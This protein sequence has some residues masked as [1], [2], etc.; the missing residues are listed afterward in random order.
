MK[1][2]LTSLILTAGVA[3]LALVFAPSSHAQTNLLTGNPLTNAPA[4]LTIGQETTF[5]S[6]V[7]SYFS[8]FDT[9][10]LTFKKTNEFDITAGADTQAG[11]TSAS[12]GINYSL[13]NNVGLDEVTRGAGI[14]G[15]IVSQQAGVSLSKVYYDVKLTAYLDGGWDF[16]QKSAFAEFGV[17]AF[18]ALTENTFAGVGLALQADKSGLR[19]SPLI[20]IFTGF[21]F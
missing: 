16:N 15:V 3:I 13:W 1:N 20:S 19:E 11:I 10:S 14:G 12:L 21:T 5:I 4:G 18:K 7:Q 8:S 17:R 9:N 6:T 2:K